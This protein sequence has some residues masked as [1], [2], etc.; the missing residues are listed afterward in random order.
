MTK[1][2]GVSTTVKYT[3]FYYVCN[4]SFSP[5]RSRGIRF[6]V[7]EPK[8]RR[9]YTPFAPDGQWNISERFFRRWCLWLTMLSAETEGLLQDGQLS[10]KPEKTPLVRGNCTNRHDRIFSLIQR[11]CGSRNAVFSLAVPIF[12]DFASFDFNTCSP[13][14]KWSRTS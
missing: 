7:A 4:V 6:V 12:V 2:G 14:Q 10:G 11:I 13:I 8:M 5:T 9:W 1:Q 3:F